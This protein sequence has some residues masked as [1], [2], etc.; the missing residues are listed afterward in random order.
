MAADAA[1]GADLF[2]VRAVVITRAEHL[3]A[4]DIRHDLDDLLRT[5][6]R[7]DAA[8]DA[9]RV[10]D[11]GNAVL[12]GDGIFRAGSGAVAE[13]HAAEDAAAVAAVEQLRRRAGGDA[14]VVSLDARSQQI[15]HL[16]AQPPL[17]QRH[18]QHHL[19]GVLMLHRRHR[20]QP[21]QLIQIHRKADGARPGGELL[22]Q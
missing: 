9:R 12:H 6:L 17:G 19:A 14:P 15:I 5:R 8:A 16:V 7:A 18:V 4:D 1:G 22:Q 2:G 13:A 20:V 3:R 10:V 11:T 21:V